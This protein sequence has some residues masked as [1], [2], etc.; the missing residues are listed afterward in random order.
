MSG[1][2]RFTRYAT[3]L[4]LQ[5]INHS[6]KLLHN[7]S[8]ERVLGYPFRWSRGR[9]R[10]EWFEPE[11]IYGKCG[12]RPLQSYLRLVGPRFA[13]VKKIACFEE[14]RV[15]RRR[16]RSP[17]DAAQSRNWE[18]EHQRLR[19]EIANMQQA[20]AG[21]CELAEAARRSNERMLQHADREMHELQED[22]NPT[23]CRS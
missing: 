15:L 11:R 4:R 9:F 19:H 8:R 2:V 21:H 6:T 13:T 12:R 3:E 1:I 22:R 18:Q 14:G 5:V 20:A 10:P 16:S 23:L 17:H 7:C